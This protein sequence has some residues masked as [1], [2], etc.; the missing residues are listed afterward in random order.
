[1]SNFKVMEV[2]IMSKRQDVNPHIYLKMPA[3][4]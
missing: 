4:E 1:M 3:F 2:I